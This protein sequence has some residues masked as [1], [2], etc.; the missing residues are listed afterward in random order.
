MRFRRADTWRKHYKQ[1]KNPDGF[2]HTFLLPLPEQDWLIEKNI[3]N[4]QRCQLYCTY[5]FCCHT[6]VVFIRLVSTEK[7]LVVLLCKAT[8]KK[9]CRPVTRNNLSLYNHKAWKGGCRKNKKDS[10]YASPPITQLNS[11]FKPP[12]KC[13]LQ[14]CSTQHHDLTLSKKLGKRLFCL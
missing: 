1:N 7:Y 11:N 6:E 2:L 9:Y 10:R 13:W 8:G 3:F 14:E 12:P 4:G 5:Y